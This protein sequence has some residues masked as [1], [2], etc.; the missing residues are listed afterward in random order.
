MTTITIPDELA[1]RLRER[2]QER[3]Q[4]LNTFALATLAAKVEEQEEEEEELDAETIA[5]LQ[6][7]LADIRAGRTLSLGEVRA[8]TSAALRERFGSGEG[9]S[10]A[11]TTASGANRA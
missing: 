2:A 5:A 11:V 8:Q 7:G 4:D 9:K 3:G 1:E 6:E 10:K